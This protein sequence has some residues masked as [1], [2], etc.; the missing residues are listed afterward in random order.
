ML[1]SLDLL[2][3]PGTG[4]IGAV[5]SAVVMIAVLVFIHELGHFLLAKACGV[6]VL[7]FSIGFGRRLFGIQIGDTDYRVSALP[8]GGYVRMAGADP[9]GYDD[10]DEQYLSDPESAYNRRPVWQRLLVMAAGPGFNLVLPVAVFT[11]LL[12]AG[13]PQPAPMVGQVQHDSP[14]FEAGVQPGDTVVSV[15]DHD[16]FAWLDMSAYVADLA[17]GTHPVVV[18]RGGDHLTFDLAFPED[19]ERAGDV[20]LTA[21]RLSTAVGVDDPASPA[22]VAGM[23][24]RDRVSAVDGRVVTDLVELN[25]ALA[26]ASDTVTLE[27]TRGEDTREVTLSRASGWLPLSPGRPLSAAEGWGLVPTSL[28]VRQVSDTVSSETSLFSGCT[29]KAPPPPSPALQHG[30]KEGDRFLKLDDR[31]LTTWSDVL[32]AV[33]G[34]MVGEGEDATARAMKVELVRAGE[35]ISLELTPTV[36]DDVDYSGL[37]Y[38]RPILGVHSQASYATLPQVRR[39]YSFGAALKRGT[40]ETLELSR[41]I[42]DRLGQLLTGEASAEKSVGGPLKMVQLASQAAERGLFTYAR[43]MGMLS[44]SLG[45]FNLL[46]VPVLDGGQ[47]LFCSMEAIRGRPVSVTFRERSYQIGILLMVMLFLW[48]FVKDIADV[49]QNGF[50]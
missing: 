19:A 7:V 48:V 44:I 39:Y 1:A 33:G 45:I 47:I 38:R 2:G 9:F 15:G 17:G 36:I 35:L 23:T 25:Q 31:P 32:S 28:F 5:L 24:T 29:P 37:Y 22:G 13:E 46:P 12:M 4:T 42:I 21:S 8:L 26:A 6:G 34:T 10:D 18:K 50:W 43:L 27:V 49:V 20:G 16:V 41:A 40:E 14:A 11:V 3:L 30:L